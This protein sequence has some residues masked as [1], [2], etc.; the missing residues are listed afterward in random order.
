MKIGFFL[1]NATFDLPGS[2]EVGGIETFTFDVGEA[3]QRLGHDVVL[4]GGRPKPGRTYRE[5]TL[6]VELFEYIETRQIPD[7]GTRFRRL[8]QRLHF[9]WGCRRA[10]L[11]ERFDVA[12]VAKPFDWPVACY[13]KARQPMQRVVMGFHGTDFYAGDRCFYGGVDAAFA[14]SCAVA[15]LAR[16]R[17]GRRPAVIPN[18][19]DLAFFAPGDTPGEARNASFRLV[20]S[21]R[22]VGLKGFVSLVRAVAALRGEGVPIECDLAG[23][24]PARTRLEQTIAEQHVVGSVRLHG[25]LAK[26]A[27]R[28]LYRNADAYVLP[29]IGLEAF[30]I[31][32]LE[33]AGVGL[34]VLLSDR[35]GLAEFLSDADCVVFRSG[36]EQALREGLRLLYHRRADVQWCD[37]AARHARLTP[38]FTPAKV[39][40]QILD[41]ATRG[42][43]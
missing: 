8:V 28:E 30:A 21:G 4:F 36:D 22:L 42:S 7:L 43:A 13:W 20:A 18:P 31:A 24:G 33:A 34:P 19:A 12:V 39:A 25:R 5:T 3:M 27:L 41:L 2:P 10:W 29:T 17:V 37:R 23:E 9:G 14:V 35:V 6:R 1:P 26:P 40:E 32:A 38:R 16:Q 11:A 15:D